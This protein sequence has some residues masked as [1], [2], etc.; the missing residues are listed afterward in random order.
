MGQPVTPSEA[1]PAVATS[2]GE[3]ALR[4]SVAGAVSFLATF[5]QTLLL[6]PIFL[7]CWGPERYGLWLALQSLYGVVIALD[8]G[9]QTYVGNEFLRLFP[10]DRGAMRS[11]LAAGLLGALLLGAFQLGV[12]GVLTLS[13]ALP[14]ALGQSDRVLPAEAPLVL[15]LLLVVWIVQGSAGGV[16][17]RLYHPAGEYARSAWWGIANRIAQTAV[18]ASAVL[19]GA[20]LLAAV[21]ASSVM[22]LIFV[23]FLW[24]EL[25]TRFHYLYPFWRGARFGAAVKNITRS[26]VVTGCA[27]LVQ[28]QQHGI[29]FV[30]SGSVGLSVVP[31]Y[32]T[33]RT[34]ANL[35]FQAATVVTSPLMPEMVR[36]SALRQHDKLADTVRAVWFVTG[37]PVN[38][39]LCLGVPFYEPLY[40]AWMRGAMPFDA[41][42]FA[43]L[44]AAISLRCFGAPL[45][46]LIAGLNALRAQVWINGLQGATMVGA[47]LLLAPRFGLKG[48]GAAVAVGELVGSVL[49]PV[50]LMWRLEPETMRRIPLRSMLVVVAASALV[51][52]ALLAV[53]AGLVQPLVGAGGAALVG[54]VLYRIQWSDLAPHVKQRLLTLLG[55]RIGA[56]RAGQS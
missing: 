26:I 17:V 36:F 38:L 2:V 44:A 19:L 5:A 24:H 7:R 52:G 15:G 12:A 34:L 43:L 6:V 21:V 33:T 1:G 13:G 4:G 42:L 49:A 35:F 40:T 27:L 20:G 50:V 29:I 25:K 16:L 47:L 10:T 30:L 51:A 22:T 23:A 54:L 11:M 48:A 37:V 8:T 14:W 9:H 3:R 55:R 31:A 18:L 28:L 56:F 32:T 39:G 46:A 41:G 45:N 53:A